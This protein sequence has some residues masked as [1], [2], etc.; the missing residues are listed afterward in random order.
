MN[1]VTEKINHKHKPF[2][3]DAMGARFGGSYVG[4][5]SMTTK[6]AKGEVE[7]RSN[8]PVSVFYNPT[9]DK[10]KGHS[11]YF[12]IFNQNINYD[13]RW[14]ICNAD[15]VKEQTIYGVECLD[16]IL[17]SAYRHDYVTS[18]DGSVFIDGGRDYLRCSSGADL[19]ILKIENGQWM[20]E[21]K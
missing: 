11:E 20:G 6:N 12:G 15:C 2:W 14:V 5:F 4:E 1:N 10:S 13:L 8:F 18:E 3:A 21:K 17:Y 16:G 9:P 7:S 19:W